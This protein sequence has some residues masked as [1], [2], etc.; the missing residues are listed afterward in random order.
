MRLTVLAACLLS[1]VAALGAGGDTSTPPPTTPTSTT[2]TDGQIW[3]AETKACV[4][5]RDSRLED[6]D[7]LNAVRELA[8]AGRTDSAVQVLGSVENQTSG[9]AQTYHGFLARQMGDMD[10]AMRHYSAALIANPDNLLARSYM[11][12]AFVLQ[13]DA[14]AA[15]AQLIEIRMRGGSGTWAEV[16]LAKA[17]HSGN[18][19]SY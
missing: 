4:D 17:I 10:S 12:Q 5:A 11:G 19:T 14:R 9:V 16:A 6:A 13:N 8:Y 1:P 15:Q 3:D 18:V 2:C 7:R